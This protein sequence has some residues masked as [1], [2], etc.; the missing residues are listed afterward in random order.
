MPQPKF[1][2]TDQG[3]LVM[4]D[5]RLSGTLYLLQERYTPGDDLNFEI[6]F[7]LESLREESS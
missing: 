5:S 7:A 4:Y 2:L 3:T 1:T 6:H